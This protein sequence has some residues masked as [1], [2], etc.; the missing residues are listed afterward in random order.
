MIM[1]GSKIKGKDLGAI[2][3]N[4]ESGD[5][6]ENIAI[7]VPRRDRV[8]DWLMIF[9]RGND[10]LARDKDITGEAFRI[11]FLLTA[12]MDYENR[13]L[14]TQAEVSRELGIKQQNVNKAFKILVSK[15]II[16]EDKIYGRTKTYKLSTDFGWKG[17]VRRLKTR[18]VEEAELQPVAPSATENASR[19]DENVAA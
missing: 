14:L 13:I 11:F 9:E 8:K 6:I 18:A 4:R 2:F 10:I 1:A 15:G 5:C 3:Y 16:V 12:N 17:S 7:V 19:S